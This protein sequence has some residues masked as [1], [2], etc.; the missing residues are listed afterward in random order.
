MF[1]FFVSR[2]KKNRGGPE[3]TTFLRT[4]KK[5][6]SAIRGEKNLHSETT[7]GR[8]DWLEIGSSVSF[9]KPSNCTVIITTASLE[10]CTTS[11]IRLDSWIR[12][13]YYSARGSCYGTWKTK[14]WTPLKSFLLVRRRTWRKTHQP[15]FSPRFFCPPIPDLVPHRGDLIEKNSRNATFSSL[16]GPVLVFERRRQRQ[17]HKQ[18]R[19]ETGPTLE[20]KTK[21]R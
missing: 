10:T 5:N 8:L 14:A 4:T 20:A 15:R 2:Q 18:L 21:K 11:E 12:I 6:P 9:W 13:L 19:G 1:I 3:K 16:A 17:V 7:P